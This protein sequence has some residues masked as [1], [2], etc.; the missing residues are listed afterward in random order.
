MQHMPVPPEPIAMAPMEPR[1]SSVPSE[2]DNVEKMIEY[3][4][5][6]GKKTPRQS[7]IFEDALETLIMAGHTFET[8]GGLGDEKFAK[9]GIL[10]GIGIQIRSQVARYKKD[11]AAGR[12]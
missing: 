9:M 7:V 1:S 5:W 4:K 2:V 8:V 10:E 6:L 3:L 12:I 11:K